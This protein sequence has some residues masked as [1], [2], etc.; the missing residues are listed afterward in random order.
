MTLGVM[1]N[2][3][4]KAKAR[5]NIWTSLIQLAID[6]C[7]RKVPEAPACAQSIRRSKVIPPA[8]SFRSLVLAAVCHAQV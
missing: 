2:C 5:A 6:Q 3:G 4:N 1:T 7:L 8:C